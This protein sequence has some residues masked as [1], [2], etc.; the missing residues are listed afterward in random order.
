MLTAVRKW[1]SGKRE[2]SEEPGPL[3]LVAVADEPLRNRI[4]AMVAENGPRVEQFS[5]VASMLAA[6]VQFNPD[7]VILDVAFGNDASEAMAGLAALNKRPALQLL[8]GN[9]IKTYEQLCVV[10]QVR[11]AADK[12]GMRM[13]TALQPPLNPEVVRRCL[14]DLGLRRS[15][16]AAVTLNQALKHEW[17]ELFYQPKIHL[18]TKRLAGAEGLIRVRHPELG[19]LPPGAF[20]PGACEEDMMKLTEHVIVAA[21]RDYDELAVDGAAVKL[22]VNTP[23]SAL[24]TLP[25]ARMVRECRPKSVNWPG[26]ILEVTEDEIINDLALANNVAEELKAHDCSLAIDDFGAGYSSLARLRQLPFRELKIDRS[27][28]ANCDKDRTNASVCETIVELAHR[29]GLMTVAEGIE[30]PHESHRL[31]AIG[32]AV[33]QGY[34]FTKPI[35]KHDFVAIMRRRM[36]HRSAADGGPKV[37]SAR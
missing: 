37:A 16:K 36:V 9:E 27:Y 31:Q 13:T 33:G 29:F 22:S 18:A 35:S 26:L 10:G 14:Q 15:G 7:L 30:T 11:L 12:A 24:T 6:A 2:E 32:C 5:G 20:L 1:F 8:C 28:V 19:V 21:L 23:V 25:I 17:L 4:G 34:L 3:C